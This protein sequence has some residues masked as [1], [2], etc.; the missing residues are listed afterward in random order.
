[1]RNEEHARAVAEIVAYHY[2]IPRDDITV[3]QPTGDAEFANVPADEY[4]V[5]FDKEP[6]LDYEG[7]RKLLKLVDDT[8][9]SNVFVDPEEHD[10]AKVTLV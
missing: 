6:G 1:L 2:G 9:A 5:Q 10:G 4:V 3:R 8:E 7:L